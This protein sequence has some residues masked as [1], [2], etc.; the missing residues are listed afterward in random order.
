MGS[1]HAV[2]FLPT[3]RGDDAPHR[4]G[5]VRTALAPADRPTILQIEAEAENLA[6][7]GDAPM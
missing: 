6:A 2:R 1:P 3:T 7:Y 5:D 4:G